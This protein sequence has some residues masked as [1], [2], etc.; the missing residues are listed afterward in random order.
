LALAEP[1][2]QRV[3]QR[4]ISFGDDTDTTA[5]VAGGI[6]GIRHGLGGIPERWL[7]A[8]AGRPLVD[9]VAQQLIEHLKSLHVSSLG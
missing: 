4:A 1:N 8:L 9:P 5:A 3:V 6:A 7:A 2:F